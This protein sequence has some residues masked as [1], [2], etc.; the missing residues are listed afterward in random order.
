MPK[1]TVVQESGEAV[2]PSEGEITRLVRESMGGD[3]R[4]QDAL[5]KKAYT[6]LKQMARNLF[7]RERTSHTLQPTAL[8][9]EAYIRIFKTGGLKAPSRAY[10]FAAVATAMRRIL[11]EHARQ[12]A[13]KQEGRDEFWN[14]VVRE[15]EETQNVGY[16]D[17]HEALEEL[18]ETAPRQHD[19]VVLRFY[20]GLKWK[21]IDEVLGDVSLSTVEKDWQAARAWLRRRLKG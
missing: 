10:F 5:V 8:V 3:P 14:R 2:T 13:G 16:I 19:V 11:I 4:A 1:E 12:R 9:H 6:E 20:G 7:I 17:L 21:E 18:K 15:L